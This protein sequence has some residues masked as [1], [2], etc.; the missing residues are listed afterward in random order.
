MANTRD[1]I[2]YIGIGMAVF[3]ALFYAWPQKKPRT[4]EEIEADYSLVPVEQGGY[5][6][7]PLDLVVPPT[8]RSLELTSSTEE[9]PRG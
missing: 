5:P 4:A 3:F 6:L 1:R 2:T 7:P 9:A 8:P